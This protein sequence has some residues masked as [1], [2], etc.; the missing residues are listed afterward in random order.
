MAK[1]IINKTVAKPI[2]LDKFFFW[3]IS[4]LRDLRSRM[5]SFQESFI[6][7]LRRLREGSATPP[8]RKTPM[9]SNL[10]QGD[11]TGSR[12]LLGYNES[13]RSGDEIGNQL[14]V[15]DEFAVVF[16]RSRV[17]ETFDVRGAN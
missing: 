5:I 8:C 16:A 10:S 9:M 6:P 14:R 2:E 4:I 15:L 7:R 13:S 17:T 11:A 12:L 3:F 1:A